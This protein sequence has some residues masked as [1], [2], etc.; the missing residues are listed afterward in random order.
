MRFFC[1]LCGQEWPEDPRLALPC[2]KCGASAGVNC[3]RPSGHTIRPQFGGAPHLEREHA[4]VD[5]GLLRRCTANPAAK[6][7]EATSVSPPRLRA[8]NGSEPTMRRRDLFR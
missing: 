3:R 6:S 1:R 2:P 5:A 4:A 8:E 7:Y